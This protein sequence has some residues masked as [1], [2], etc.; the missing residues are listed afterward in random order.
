LFTLTACLVFPLQ[1][2]YSRRKYDPRTNPPYLRLFFHYSD[3]P[4]SQPLPGSD[5]DPSGRGGG[6]DQQQV[7]FL[8]GQLRDK[9]RRIQELNMQLG[10]AQEGIERSENELALAR[11]V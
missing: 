5:A 7:A 10:E 11:S 6:V 4:A 2:K 1:R 9:D 8:Q 3:E